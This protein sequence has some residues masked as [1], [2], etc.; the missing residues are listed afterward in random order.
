MHQ[1]IPENFVF[2]HKPNLIFLISLYK[3]YLAATPELVAKN[4][5][6]VKNSS[7]NNNNKWINIWKN[8]V[9]PAKL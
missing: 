5:S 4:N 8:N 9:F 3:S 2:K 6:L 7:S 1:F